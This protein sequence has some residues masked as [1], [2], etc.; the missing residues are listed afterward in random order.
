MQYGKVVAGRD[1]KPRLAVRISPD[2]VI[3]IDIFE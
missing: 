3:T 1:G 2:K